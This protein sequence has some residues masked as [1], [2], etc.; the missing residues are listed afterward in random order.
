MEWPGA[1]NRLGN[2]QHAI[3]MACNYMK[4]Q[5]L[6]VGRKSCRPAWGRPLR[7]ISML[8]RVSSWFNLVIVRAAAHGVSAKSSPPTIIHSLKHTIMI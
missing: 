3:M 6:V 4:L 7:L 1:F 2:G 8:A 5:G